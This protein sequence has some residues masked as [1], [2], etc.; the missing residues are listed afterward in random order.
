M[1]N[2]R[3]LDN[4]RLLLLEVKTRDLKIKEILVKN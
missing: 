4:L 2:L 3:S 1:L